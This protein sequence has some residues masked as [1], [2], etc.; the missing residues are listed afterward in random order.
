LREDAKIRGIEN[1]RVMIG[2]IQVEKF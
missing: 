1:L 2:K